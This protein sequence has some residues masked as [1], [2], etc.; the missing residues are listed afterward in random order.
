M[1]AWLTR[2]VSSLTLQDIDG[3]DEQQQAIK[4]LTKEFEVSTEKLRSIVRQFIVEM[5]K[6]LE[7]HG[8]TGM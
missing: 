5:S 2:K 7:R 1:A 4:D 3:S 6:G 8:A